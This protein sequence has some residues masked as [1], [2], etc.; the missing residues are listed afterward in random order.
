MPISIPRQIVRT[1]TAWA[2]R[3]DRRPLVIKGARQV[4]KSYTVREF[5]KNHFKSFIELN[6]ETKPHLKRAFSSLDPELICQ[7]IALEYNQRI[8][9]G[10]TLLFI[11][12]I[13]EAPLAFAALRYFYERIPALHVV[14]AGSLL[15]ITLDKEA[16][17]KVPVGRLEYLY[18][19][20]L[21]FIEFLGARKEELAIEAIENLNVAKPPSESVHARLLHLFQEYIMVGGMPAVVDSYIK[22]SLNADYR[23]FQSDL[24]QG[25]RDDFRKYRSRI[26]VNRIE[27]VFSRLP[28][29]V[30]QACKLNELAPGISQQTSKNILHLLKRSHVLHFV[31]RSA[32]NGIPLGG[33]IGETRHNKYIFLDI[34]LL[35][36]AQGL[37]LE[38]IY[39]WNSELVSSG[40]L[41]EQVVGQELL[42]YG[43]PH[44]EPQLYYWSREKRGSS[45]EVDFVTSVNNTVVPI[46]V[47]AGATGRLKSLRLFMQ[48][49]RVPV[50]VRFSQHDISLTDGILSIPL[51]AVSCL[52]RLLKSI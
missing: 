20:P 17:L 12:E 47:K 49:K 34:G 22:D 5:G 30:G 19:F 10:E 9:P 15:D 37:K 4:G 32:A 13:Q 28:I 52:D 27:R 1:L 50:G 3:A 31:L 40:A 6:L 25:Y 46:E 11:D 23:I 33:Q 18:M 29:C 2:N 48:E 7:A 42:A 16:D 14:A 36:A 21:S 51:Y 44:F 43:D 8:V 24:L 45:A 39:S 35:V 26:D 38:A 41:A